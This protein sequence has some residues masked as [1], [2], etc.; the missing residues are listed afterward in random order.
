VRIRRGWHDGTQ[1]A[2]G[3]RRSVFGESIF[4]PRARALFLNPAA[5][6]VDANQ[7][8]K[9]GEKTLVIPRSAVRHQGWCARGYSSHI[10]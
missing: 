6:S 9:A 1:R 5:T 10:T 7:D 8:V 2:P 3:E 4:T